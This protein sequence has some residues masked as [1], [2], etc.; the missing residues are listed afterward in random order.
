MR[1]SYAL[2]AA[3]YDRIRDLPLTVDGYGL[4]GL[5]V[6][7]GAGWLRRTTVIRL[8]GAGHEGVG[9]DVTYDGGDQAVFQ[10]AGATLDLA[11]RHTIDSFSELIGSLD[12]FPAAPTSEVYR[13]YRRW[14]YEAAGLDLALRQAGLGLGEALGLEPRPVSF[15]VSMGLGDPPSAERVQG[16]LAVD[17]SL[18]F[19]LDATPGWDEPLIADLAATGAVDV[20][21]LKAFYENTPVDNPADPALYRRVAEGLADA[22]LEDALVTPDTDPVLAAHRDRLAWDAPIHSVADILELPYPPRHMNIKPSRFGSVRGL[23]EAYDHC[24]ERGIA[25]YGGGQFELGPGRAQIQHLASLFHPAAANDVAP[26]A[27]NLGPQPGLQ[28]SPLPA[29]PGSAPFGA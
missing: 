27:Y 8:G 9:E 26:P 12:L 10:D 1:V 3:L 17:P 20:V 6:T 15:V 21:D 2:V 25:T 19:K 11:G 18:R 4:S 5:D 7:V 23:L 22:V 16:W 28:H 29:W 24:R 13:Q 14:S